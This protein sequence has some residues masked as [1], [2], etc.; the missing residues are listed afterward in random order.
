V[1]S[2]DQER[3]LKKLEVFAYKNLRKNSIISIAD[4]AVFAVGSGMLPVST[5]IVYLFQTM[6]IQIH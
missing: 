2:E 3:E 6:S 5:V 4:G 1:T